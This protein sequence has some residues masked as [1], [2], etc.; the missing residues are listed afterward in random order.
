MEITSAADAEDSFIKAGETI[1]VKVAIPEGKNPGV[2]YMMFDIAYDAAVF[3]LDEKSIATTDIFV[4]GSPDLDRAGVIIDEEN[5]V[6]TFI[7]NMFANKNTTGTGNVVT[8]KF[9]VKNGSCADTEIAVANLIAFNETHDEIKTEAGSAKV[10]I[11]DFAESKKVAPTC[12]EDGYTTFKCTKCDVSYNVSDD[13]SKAL[14]HDFSKVSCT[15]DSAC[16]RCNLAGDKAT[17]HNYSSWKVEKEAAPGVA[18]ESVRTCSNCGDKQTEVIPEL[19]DD[20]NGSAVAII[21][22]VVI[23]VLAVAGFC[24]YWFVL[25]KN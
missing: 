12:T 3:D 15:E 24:V 11:H 8:L 18:G 21:V 14:G 2:A 5:G 6:V 17:G 1:E 13:A 10:L 16:T 19:P 22:I 25:R 7:T 4:M 23:V 20:G 9:A